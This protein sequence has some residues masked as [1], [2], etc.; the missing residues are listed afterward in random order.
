MKRPEEGIS[1]FLEP[2]QDLFFEPKIASFERK[3]RYFMER[4]GY[5]GHKI[6][7][8]AAETGGFGA[9]KKILDR[10]LGILVILG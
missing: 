5:T 6:P 9:G 10:F 4:I 3:T 1:R 8:F 2:V 7:G